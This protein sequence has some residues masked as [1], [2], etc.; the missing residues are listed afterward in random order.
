MVALRRTRDL[1]NLAIADA[2]VNGYEGLINGLTLPDP[3]DR[4]VLAAAIRASAQ[5]I[6]TANLDDFP[7]DKLQQYGVE[8][9]HPDEFVLHLVDLAS[10][11]VCN[12][13]GE[14]AA[15]L[16]NPART[17]ADV[18]DALRENGLVRSVARLRELFGAG[19]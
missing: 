8:A 2:L 1:M 9:Q 11:L 4:H 17:V 3:D 13:V 14:Q 10:G 5:V 6:V 18:L 7:S 19:A 16:R 15:A 12:T